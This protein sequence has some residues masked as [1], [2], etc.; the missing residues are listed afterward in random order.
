MACIKCFL[1]FLIGT[2]NLRAQQVDKSYLLG[3]FN[4]ER[5]ARFEKIP[6]EYS[7]GSGNGAYLRKETLQAFSNM[8]KAAKKDGVLLIIVSATRNFERQKAIWENKW[9]GNT[10]VEGKNLSLLKDSLEKAKIIMR[11]SAMPGTSRHHWGT[12]IDLNNVEDYYFD[13]PEGKGVY[14]WL[15]ANASKFGFCQPYTSKIATQRTG[16]EEEKWHWSYL[17]LSSILLNQYVSSISGKDV[18]GFQGSTSFT[19]LKVMTHYVEGVSCK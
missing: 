7:S 13:T 6:P 9:N 1:F 16:Y 18:K 4:P 5:D 3:L 8:R 12:D 19:S 17:P 11:F 10:L 2:F 14:K 15:V